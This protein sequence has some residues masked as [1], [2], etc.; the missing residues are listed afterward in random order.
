MD[1]ETGV[2]LI[3]TVPTGRQPRPRLTVSSGLRKAPTI[4]APSDAGEQ[5]CLR[6]DASAVIPEA[7][8]RPATDAELRML[9]GSGPV[10]PGSSIT[11]VRMPENILAGLTQ[12]RAALSSIRDPA[13]ANDYFSRQDNLQLAFDYA[14][15]LMVQD[16]A[17][18]PSGV[19][20]N[21]AGLPTVTIDSSSEHLVGLHVDNWVNSLLAQ[22]DSSPG[23]IAMN[24]GYE[25]RYLIYVNLPLKRIWQLSY[26]SGP[27]A[28]ASFEPDLISRFARSYP[29]YPVARLRIAPGEAYIAPTDNIIHD[30]STA[31]MATWDL[32]F[33]V[34][35]HFPAAVS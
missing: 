33:T 9:C 31:G 21:L 11:V 23:R 7:D 3:D 1:L 15:Q 35:G 5:A 26:A 28:E 27:V 14:Y 13:Q 19:R 10:S 29:S 12:A 25:D 4:W 34:I 18:Y 6:Y 30:G 17:S 2:V 32:F 24:L 20:V 8:W 16:G 22:R